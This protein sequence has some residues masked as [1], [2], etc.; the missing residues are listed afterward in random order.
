[1]VDGSPSEQYIDGIIHLRA[2]IGYLGE[3]GQYGWWQTS[4]LTPTGF[5]FLEID[6]PRSV[7]LAAINSVTHAAK[8]LH[9]QT[10]G[11]GRVYHLFRLPVGLEQA[12]HERLH[13]MDRAPILGLISSKERALFGLGSFGSE[14]SP[15][16]N[17]SIRIGE[18]KAVDRVKTLRHI[19]GHYRS[20][21]ETGG[22]VFPYFSEP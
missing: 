9:D 12:I 17:G 4:F 18:V 5:R 19:A 3:K 6:F 15:N 20:A 11:K 13:A 16:A 22:R 1:M 2:A 7:L 14:E 10:I 21:F 8:L